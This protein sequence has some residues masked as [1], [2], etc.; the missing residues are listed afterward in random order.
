MMKMK[1]NRRT[2][3]PADQAALENAEAQAEVNKAN[4]DYLAMMTDIEI[5]T[6]EMEGM[7]DE[8]EI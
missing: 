4:I 7:N 6:E 3:N 2:M 1:I 5:P 8:S